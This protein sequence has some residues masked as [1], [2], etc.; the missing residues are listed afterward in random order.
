MLVN[1]SNDEEQKSIE[2]QT[3]EVLKAIDQKLYIITA[4]L[5]VAALIAMFT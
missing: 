5:V 1:R 2:Q 3:L 4:I